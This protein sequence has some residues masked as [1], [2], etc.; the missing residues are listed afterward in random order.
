MRVPVEEIK[1]ALDKSFSIPGLYRRQE[2]AFLYKLARRRG[3]LVEL[4]CWMGRTTSI[5]LQASRIFHAQLTT[6][7]AFTAMPNDRKAAT[8]ERWQKNLKK[9]GLTPPTLLAM[10][11]NEAITIYPHDQEIALLFIDAHHGYLSV[12]FDL[13]N[14]TPLIKIGGCVALHDMFFPSITGVCQAV[15]EWWCKERDGNDPRWELIG[16]RDFTI[17]FRRK[18]SGE[19]EDRIGRAPN[20]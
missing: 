8:P 16:Q 20:G 13:I 18:L 3:K 11:T 17:A 1:M 2:A 12:M 7:D 9:I 19:H 10:T 15:T 14:W 5:M 6:V 4:G